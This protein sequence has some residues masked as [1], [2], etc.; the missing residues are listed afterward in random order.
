VVYPIAKR[1]HLVD[2]VCLKDHKPRHIFLLE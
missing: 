2:L 1:E